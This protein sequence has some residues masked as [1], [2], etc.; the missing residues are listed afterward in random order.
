VGQ[1]IG[2]LSF[3]TSM[4]AMR[5]SSVVKAWHTHTRCSSSESENMGPQLNIACCA[6]RLPDAKAPKHSNE[7]YSQSSR[8]QF[9]TL[10]K[11]LEH[12]PRDLKDRLALASHAQRAPVGKICDLLGE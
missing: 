6:Q 10:V 7:T 2:A 5:Q 3:D 9:H 1:H 11:P 4:S 8:P 12:A